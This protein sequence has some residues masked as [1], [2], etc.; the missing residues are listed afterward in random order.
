MARKRLAPP[1]GI[2]KDYQKKIRAHINKVAKIIRE[3]VVKSLPYLVSENDA[4]TRM[5]DI[6]ESVIELIRQTRIE[7]GGLEREVDLMVQ[8]TARELSTWNRSQITEF[9]RQAIGIDVFIAEPWLVPKMNEFVT[10]NVSL[11][12]NV[13]NSFVSETE[14]VVFEGLRRGLRHEEIASQ[15]L[16]YGKD[17]LNHVSRF[18]QAKTR[19]NLIGRDQVNKMNGQLTRLRQTEI[20]VKEYIWRTV[21]D[22]R[23]RDSH[24]HREGEKYSWKKGSEIG[25]HPGDEIQCRCFAEPDLSPLLNQK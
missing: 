4:I 20:G 17:D 13:S 18:R 19:A 24:V 7:V 14:R 5:D 21:N 9:I 15:I 10:S 3:R 25:T 23:V 11:I 22:H 1:I 16:G 8:Q 6:G 2:E 12:K